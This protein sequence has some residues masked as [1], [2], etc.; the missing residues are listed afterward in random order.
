LARRLYSGY[1]CHRITGA[2]RGPPPL[3]PPFLRAVFE[4]FRE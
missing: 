1:I 3:R 2:C 4:L